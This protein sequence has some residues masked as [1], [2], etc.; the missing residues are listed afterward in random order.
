MSGSKV[1]SEFFAFHITV[2]S[3]WH[4]FQGVKN[5]ARLPIWQEAKIAMPRLVICDREGQSSYGC[6]LGTW[7]F[8]QNEAKFPNIFRHA[9]EPDW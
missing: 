8:W 4:G 5:D 6:S 7:N 1:F 9:G 3:D 2:I